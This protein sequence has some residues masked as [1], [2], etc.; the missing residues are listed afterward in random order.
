MDS[1]CQNGKKRGV[2]G[3]NYSIDVEIRER[4]EIGS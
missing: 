4:N 1:I 3:R 2:R